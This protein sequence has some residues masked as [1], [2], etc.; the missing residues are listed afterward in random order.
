M[1]VINAV[2]ARCGVLVW[3][4][5]LVLGCQKKGTSEPQVSPDPNVTETAVASAAAPIAAPSPGNAADSGEVHMTLTLADGEA[6]KAAL[7]AQLQKQTDL[8]GGEYLFNATRNI[9]PTTDDGALRIGNWMLQLHRDKLKLTF[10]MPA[11]NVAARMYT[12]PVIRQGSGWQV[13]EV[14][15]GEIRLR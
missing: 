6:I 1:P 2:T 8:E 7:L 13:G 4:A 9:A 15:S 10:R 14:F 11:G 5:L 3:G 12:A